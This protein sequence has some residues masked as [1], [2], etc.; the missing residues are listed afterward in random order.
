MPVTQVIIRLFIA[1]I[2][3]LVLTRLMGRKEIS[4]L[5]FFNFISAMSIGTIGASLAIDSTIS[6]KNGIIALLVWS[7]FTIIIGFLDIT[8]PAVRFAVHASHSALKKARIDIDTLQSLLRKK[9]LF[10]CQSG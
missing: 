5:P 7:A 1:F 8:F 2:I 9:Y 3:L 4:Q 6:T 10:N